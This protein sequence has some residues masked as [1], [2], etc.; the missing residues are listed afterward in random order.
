MVYILRSTFVESYV[1]QKSTRL[2]FKLYK[3]SRN[4]KISKSTLLIFRNLDFSKVDYQYFIVRLYFW[5]TKWRSPLKKK[6]K[7]SKFL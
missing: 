7:F 3:M 2:L 5:L 1:S 4:F 6:E